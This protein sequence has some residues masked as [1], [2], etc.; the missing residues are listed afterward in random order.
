MLNFC[1]RLLKVLVSSNDAALFPMHGQKVSSEVSSSFQ[2]FRQRNIASKVGE[3]GG[4]RGKPGK[5]HILWAVSRIL[6]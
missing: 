1:H 4:K 6:S 3:V 5:Q 2:S